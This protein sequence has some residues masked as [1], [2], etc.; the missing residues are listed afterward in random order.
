MRSRLERRSILTFTLVLSAAAGASTAATV[1]VNDSGDTTNPCATTGTGTCTLR[2]AITYAN[3]NAGSTIA[4]NIAGAG[5]H[6]I[7]PASA[8]PELTAAVTIDGY[9]QPGSSPNTLAAGDDAVLNIQLSGPG[10][11]GGV[12]LDVASRLGGMSLLRAVGGG[13]PE[14]SGWSRSREAALPRSMRELPSAA[15]WRRPVAVC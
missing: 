4:F 5:V 3:A 8:L 1:T 15:R 10:A 12:G 6:T 2:D 11:E 14:G 7:S 13:R 9:T